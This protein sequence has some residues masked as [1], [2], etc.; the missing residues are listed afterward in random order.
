MAPRDFFADAGAVGAVVEDLLQRFNVTIILDRNTVA[1]EYVVDVVDHE[2][3][4]AMRFRRAT[5][6]DAVT[7]ARVALDAA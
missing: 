2:A 6:L 4:G 1:G 5:L 3:D 7:A